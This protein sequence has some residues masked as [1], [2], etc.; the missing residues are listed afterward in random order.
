M[1]MYQAME[2]DKF[3]V[4]DTLTDWFEEFRMY[5]RKE[6]KVVPIRDDIMSATRYAFQSKRF[7]LAGHDPSWTNEVEYKQ[8]GI[9]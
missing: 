5:H 8:Y 2:S 3:K 1:A 7:A 4:F 9:I 6:G